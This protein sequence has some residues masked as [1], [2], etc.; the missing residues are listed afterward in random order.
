[1]TKNLSTQ[2]SMKG[3]QPK[4][5]RIPSLTGLRPDASSSAE[6]ICTASDRAHRMRPRTA[7]RLAYPMSQL[8]VCGIRCE[9]CSGDRQLKTEE[10]WAGETCQSVT[11]QSSPARTQKQDYSTRWGAGILRSL[12]SKNCD[13]VEE[14]VDCPRGIPLF[15]PVPDRNF[16]G[17]SLTALPKPILPRLDKVPPSDDSDR[18]HRRACDDYTRFSR[19]VRSATEQARHRNAAN[20]SEENPDC[21]LQNGVLF[22]DYHKYVPRRKQSAPVSVSELRE[23]KKTQTFLEFQMALE[24]LKEAQH[25]LK[26]QLCCESADVQSSESLEI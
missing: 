6:C 24:A 17:V 2:E 23:V 22:I 5:I 4:V 8:N 25:R 14:K 19:R 7:S 10:V 3:R 20:A 18:R 15:R 13:W 11:S 21:L 16:S 1:M 12:R 9:N 26:S